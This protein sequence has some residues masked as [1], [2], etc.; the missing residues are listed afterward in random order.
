MNHILEFCEKMSLEVEGKG[1][2]LFEFLYALE[3]TRKKTALRVEE[4]KVGDE[5]ERIRSYGR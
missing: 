3:T 4:E 5:G 1:T 2:D